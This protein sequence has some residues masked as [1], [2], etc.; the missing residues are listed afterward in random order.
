MGDIFFELR[1]ELMPVLRAGD[2]S[3]CERA[4]ADRLAALPQSP[5]HVAI[6]LSITNFELRRVDD[7]AK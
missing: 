7:G 1:D 2:T 3:R 4:V 5:F 6:E